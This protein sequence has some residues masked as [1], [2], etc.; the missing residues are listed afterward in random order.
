MWALEI[1]Q[2]AKRY[3]DSSAAG[4]IV[5]KCLST[6]TKHNKDDSECLLLNEHTNHGESSASDQT[7]GQLNESDAP[8]DRTQDDQCDREPHE[9][10]SVKAKN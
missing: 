1:Q 4:A 6:T 7:P 3:D 8:I 2:I 9:I 10:S 5:N